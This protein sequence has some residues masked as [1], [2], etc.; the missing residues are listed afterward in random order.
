[1]VLT[2]AMGLGI[3]APAEAGK[4]QKDNAATQS[5]TQQAVTPISQYG[6]QNSL[7]EKKDTQVHDTK[8]LK[9]AISS[10]GNNAEGQKNDNAK[11]NIANHEKFKLSLRATESANK[12]IES[13]RNTG[14]LPSNYITKS[15]ATQRGWKPGKALN[16]SVPD[17]Q[18][19]GD[20]FRNIP[21][22]VPQAPGRTWFEADIGISN[23]ASRN[24]Q[25]G[26]RLL[27]SNDGLLYM[28][29]DHYKTVS[30]I[31]TWR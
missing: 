27:Y 17:G 10:G 25:P 26:T 5:Q 30:P 12:I 2:V 8:S 1:M 13:L 18:I 11:H 22:I 21:S 19:G 29:T 16:N 6:D 23:K 28:T 20:F 7:A 14:K 9:H 24:N 4:T 3:Q 15:Q 31:G